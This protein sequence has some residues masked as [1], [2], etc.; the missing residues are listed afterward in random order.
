MLNRQKLQ[1]NF[2]YLYAMFTT[3]IY[4]VQCIYKLYL[5]CIYTQYM[6]SIRSTT[7]TTIYKMYKQFFFGSR[8]RSAR[9]DKHDYLIYLATYR[10]QQAQLLVSI[11]ATYQL[12]LLY[13]QYTLDYLEHKSQNTRI[14]SCLF[15]KR[16]NQ[17]IELRSS[18]LELFSIY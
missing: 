13:T 4:L 2:V 9:G 18:K 11:D 5:N 14:Y 15:R 1:C 16:L 7:T 6:I 10:V 17:S 12:F 3:I 8:M